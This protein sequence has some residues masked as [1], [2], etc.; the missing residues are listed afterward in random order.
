LRDQLTE[1]LRSHAARH[2]TT[3][4][5]TGARDDVNRTRETSRA[6]GRTSSTAATTPAILRLAQS[7]YRQE[8][9]VDGWRKIFTFLDK[10]LA[11]AAAKAAA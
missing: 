9:A 11:T 7:P 4:T 10:H 1:K 6:P 5:R 2:L 8:Q 3:T